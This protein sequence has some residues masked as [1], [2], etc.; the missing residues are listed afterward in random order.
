MKATLALVVAAVALVVQPY[1]PK[2]IEVRKGERVM[3]MARYDQAALT[4]AA[5]AGI[6]VCSRGGAYLCGR[7]STLLIASR[8]LCALAARLVTA[9]ARTFPLYKQ[10]TARRS[11]RRATFCDT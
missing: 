9:H 2:R 10:L 4:V 5:R 11:L 7:H 3:S 1:E 6:A 8:R